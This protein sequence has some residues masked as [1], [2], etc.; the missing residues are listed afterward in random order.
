MVRFL[1]EAEALA[2]LEE[3]WRVGACFVAIYLTKRIFQASRV[4]ELDSALHVIGIR[5]TCDYLRPLLPPVVPNNRAF[6][7]PGFLLLLRVL[8]TLITLPLRWRCRCQR[9]VCWRR[10]N[11]PKLRR[12]LFTYLYPRSSYASRLHTPRPHLIVAFPRHDGFFHD[13][14]GSSG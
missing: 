8:T 12:F 7:S 10:V 1:T 9:N 14:I 13:W 3:S 2:L 5:S 11:R 4:R 6:A